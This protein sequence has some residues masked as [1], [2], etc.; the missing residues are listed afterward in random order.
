MKFFCEYC[1][2]RIDAEKDIKCP[3]CGASYDK[4]ESFIE[5]EKNR[6]QENQLNNEY[7]HKIIKHVLNTMAFSKVFA[8]IPIF[9]FLI[10][11]I[12]VIS[13]IDFGKNTENTKNTKKDNITEMQDKF[14]SII[15]DN[16]NEQEKITVGI[17]D[18]AETN[19]YKVKVNKYEVVEDKFNRLDEGYELVKFHLIVENLTAGEIT[20]EDVYCIVDGV[21]QTND[22]TSGYSDLPM[23]IAKDLTVTGTATFEVPKSTTSF[24]IR[25]GDYVTIHIEK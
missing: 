3:H 7:K 4:N 12:I 6:A 20:K 16:S 9:V 18:F 14:N 2:N 21:S 10:V 5:L 11:L 1:G 22:F 17:N 13:F 23:F 24:D 15:N 8:I 19:E 25:Y